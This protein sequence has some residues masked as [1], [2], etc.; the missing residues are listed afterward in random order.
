MT[1]LL[2]AIGAI[3]VVMIIASEMKAYNDAEDAHIKRAESD[4]KWRRWEP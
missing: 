4:R 2:C 3:F 1:L